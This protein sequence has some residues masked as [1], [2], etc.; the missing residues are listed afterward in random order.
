MATTRDD[1]SLTT[2]KETLRAEARARRLAIPREQRDADAERLANALLRLPEFTRARLV[3][4]YGANCEEI[5]PA[6]A[7]SRLRDLGLRVAYPRVASKDVLDLHEVDDP[8]DLVLGAFS[9][10]EPRPDAPRVDASDVD[11]V[12]VPGVA[13]D[14]RGH[15]LG[16][17]GGFYD[18]FLGALPKGPLRIGLAFDEQLFDE[19]PAEPHDEPVDVVVTPSVVVYARGR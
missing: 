7:V 6:L 19:V 18:R 3:L 14:R 15:R 8:D 12:L 1:G 13:F 16:Y 10:R 4:A 17:G 2:R 11:A 5:D 9:I